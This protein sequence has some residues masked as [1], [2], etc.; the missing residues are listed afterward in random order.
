MMPGSGL[1]F[2]T[3]VKPLLKSYFSSAEI[4]LPAVF[5]AGRDFDARHRRLLHRRLPTDRGPRPLARS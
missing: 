5:P 1:G 4:S 3:V 2:P